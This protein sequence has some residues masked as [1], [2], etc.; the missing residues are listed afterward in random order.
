MIDPLEASLKVAG[1]GLAAQSARLRVVSENMANAQSTGKTPGADPY[2]RKTI[3]FVNEL[4]RATGLQ[5]VRVNG[6]GVDA[7]PF[8]IE[9]D[10][11]HP[12]ADA[13]GDVKRPNVNL[14]VEMA[15]MREA[16]R[17]YEADLQIMKQSRDLLAMT[18]DLLK[19]L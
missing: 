3:A 18:V 4:D 17:A 11:G 5:L 19:G 6:V 9:R 13:N 12:A 15:D 8:A 7:T 1:A 14:L 16:N 10:P 2:A